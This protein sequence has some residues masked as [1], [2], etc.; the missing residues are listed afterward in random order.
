MPSTRVP[1]Q[2]LEQPPLTRGS[3]WS[4]FLHSGFRRRGLAECVHWPELRPTPP[5]GVLHE[6]GTDSAPVATA[7]PRADVST[8][9]P[10]PVQRTELSSPSLRPTTSVGPVEE[11]RSRGLR[12][13]CA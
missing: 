3:R 4:S 13:F 8:P 1:L 5:R 9:D 6:V 7:R 2:A 10:Q 11:E 12:D